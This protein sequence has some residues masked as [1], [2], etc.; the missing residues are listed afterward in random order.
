MLQQRANNTKAFSRSPYDIW[1]VISFCLHVREPRNQTTVTNFVNPFINML[2][3]ILQHV[4][5]VVLIFNS[6]IVTLY[7]KNIQASDTVHAW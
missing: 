7:V 1:W 4:T 2:S 3:F 5:R 6:V